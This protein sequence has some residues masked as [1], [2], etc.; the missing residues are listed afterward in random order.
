MWQN[1]KKL[2]TYTCEVCGGVLTLTAAEY[3]REQQGNRELGPVEM[4]AR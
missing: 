4:R 2:N 1:P 3:R